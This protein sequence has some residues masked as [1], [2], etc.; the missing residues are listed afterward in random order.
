MNDFVYDTEIVSA[1]RYDEIAC[2]HEISNTWLLSDHEHSEN[3][4]M[5]EYKKDPDLG[6][7]NDEQYFS[8]M[9]KSDTEKRKRVTSVGIA[10]AVTAY[11]RMSIYEYSRREDVVYTDTDSIVCENRLDDA[12]IGPALG[13]MKLEAL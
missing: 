8:H 1:A 13:A 11:A 6:L 12:Y 7:C 5:V 3:N 9:M 4:I 2:T 10:A